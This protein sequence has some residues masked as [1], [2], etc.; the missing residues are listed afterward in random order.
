MLLQLQELLLCLLIYTR[1][2]LSSQDRRMFKKETPGLIEIP[3][4]KDAG[5]T[6]RGDALA[7]VEAIWWRWGKASGGVG[8]GPVCGGLSLTNLRPPAPNSALGLSFPHSSSLPSLGRLSHLR[9]NKQAVSF[10]HYSPGSPPLQ[11]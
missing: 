1:M 8:D 9:E 2:F 11:P 4:Q 6:C 7:I 10:L 5:K 3:Q